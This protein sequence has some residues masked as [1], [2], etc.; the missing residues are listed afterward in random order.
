ML[1]WF[2]TKFPNEVY[3]LEHN[4]LE[5]SL[6][7]FY[8]GF[9]KIPIFFLLQVRPSDDLSFLFGEFLHTE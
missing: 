5:F 3:I 7:I 6:L 8:Y 1:I 2:L 9:T 4:I